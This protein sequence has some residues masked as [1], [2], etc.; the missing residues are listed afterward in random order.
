MVQK[1]ATVKRPTARK[2]A[3][4]K[5]YQT[6]VTATETMDKGLPSV[7]ADTAQPD[8]TDKVRQRIMFCVV[9]LGIFSI[10]SGL[11]LIIAA[12][13]AIIPPIVKTTAGLCTLAAS[14][15]GTSYSQ[16]NGKT[17]WTEALL[18][19]SFLLVGGNIA[20]IQQSYHLSLSWEAGSLLWWGLSLPLVF[21][22]RNRLLPLCSV[23]LFGF[24]VWEII[25]HIHYMVVVGIL[26]IL[27][28][29]TQIWNS[30]TAT[31]LRGLFFTLAI[32]FLY[33]GDIS[34]DTGAGFVGFLTTTAFLIIISA[35]PKNEIG[36]IRYYN[37]LFI[38]V[39]W[40]IFLLFWNAYYNLTSIGVML[41]GF[42]SILLLGVALY[43]YYFKQIQE[44]IKGL[45]KHE[46]N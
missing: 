30:K 26:F 35:A 9:L 22:S 46:Q 4:Q 28:M 34:I 17:L 44:I 13:W 11:G 15:I 38:F 43:T 7:S 3:S 39:A 32:I 24:G 40:R 45:I 41:I 21:F 36:K 27:M 16:R 33:V 18:F 42:G 25:W 20:L 37:C 29:A 14:L 8:M 2:K 12:N 19:V 23:G 5:S 31:F 1:K 6:A 10:L